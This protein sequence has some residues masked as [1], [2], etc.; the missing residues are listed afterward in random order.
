MSQSVSQVR[1]VSAQVVD[2]AVSEKKERG[3]EADQAGEQSALV[4]GSWSASR[5]VPFST[6]PP[7]SP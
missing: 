1:S 2:V 5:L 7:L 3:K 6:L 4:G